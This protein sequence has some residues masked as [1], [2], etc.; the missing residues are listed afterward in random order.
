MAGEI[1]ADLEEQQEH[2]HR[3]KEEEDAYRAE[4]A[5]K[6]NEKKEAK[7]DR[8]LTIVQW[9]QCMQTYMTAVAIVGGRLSP[10]VLITHMQVMG[11]VM[12]QLALKPHVHMKSAFM[13]YDTATREKWKKAT[14]GNHS[15]F[16][17]GDTVGYICWDRLTRI[18]RENMVHGG[19]AGSAEA[20]TQAVGV[21]NV[22]NV[23]KYAKTGRADIHC[24]RCGKL[25]HYA[26]ECYVQLQTAGAGSSTAWRPQADF[27]PRPVVAPPG[28]P[29]LA[30]G[31][32]YVEKGK[33]K[34]GVPPANA[35]TF[36]AADRIAAAFNGGKGK[37]GGKGKGHGSVPF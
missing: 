22:G 7:K 9:Y 21:Q 19:A 16:R 5:R 25:G 8:P 6:A 4:R 3:T 12:E 36:G 34:K 14:S 32:G 20:V 1:C 30:I 35:A 31:N 2:T 11:Q 23:G 10:G 37:K 33:G 29:Q 26:R 17:L 18:E 27:Q 13:A 24:L 15:G 28:Q